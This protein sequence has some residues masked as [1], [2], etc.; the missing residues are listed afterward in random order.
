MHLRE[1]E[2][3]GGGRDRR[4]RVEP[5]GDVADRADP[6]DADEADRDTDDRADRHLVDE[7]HGHV[8]HAV[9]GQL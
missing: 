1:T 6:A 8:E 4:D 5:G 7:Q 9:V 3:R 2:R